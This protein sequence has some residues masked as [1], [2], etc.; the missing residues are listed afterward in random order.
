MAI[1]M[2]EG[3]KMYPPE[4]AATY[5]S[6]S[7][8]KGG[9]SL[10]TT[11]AS[12]APST[13]NQSYAIQADSIFPD[14][15]VLR[16]NNTTAST[17]QA[18]SASWDFGLSSPPAKV[19]IG[20][21]MLMVSP[22]ATPTIKYDV[23]YGVG[24]AGYHVANVTPA[25]ARLFFRVYFAHASVAAPLGA[26]LVPGSTLTATTIEWNRTYHVELLLESDTN[27]IRMYLDGVLV[28][29]AAYAGTVSDLTKGFCFFRNRAVAGVFPWEIGNIYAAQIDSVH[30]GPFGPA[31]L[32]L[33]VAP[34]VDSTVQFQRDSVKYASNAAVVG[35]D[36]NSTDFVTAM[37]S[38]TKDL[39]NG[40]SNLAT[41]AA[42]VY[43][44]AIKVR[45][46]SFTTDGHNLR[47]KVAFN[48]V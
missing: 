38:G 6:S 10:L 25:D 18:I 41:S 8:L 35:Q 42:Q 24:P 28:G 26:L 19:L 27:R 34:T 14:R 39:F 11:V 37:D 32:V 3:F 9:W 23:A 36:V 46:Q 48:G 31:A 1:L 15:A 20:F 4:T 33:E 21:T 2:A 43:G 16:L 29:D 5:Q 47:T 44:V 12:Y 40:S 7:L 45:A 17:P 22:V 13:S 30:T